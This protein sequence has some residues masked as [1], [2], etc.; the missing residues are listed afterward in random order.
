MKGISEKTDGLLES[1]HPTDCISGTR[2]ETVLKSLGLTGW[3]KWLLQLRITL[4]VGYI[5][6]MAGIATVK[7]RISR[8]LASLCSLCS[9]SVRCVRI[10]ILEEEL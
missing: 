4:L 1:L 5:F 6:L 2:L 10:T 3:G 9:P 8:L 7:C